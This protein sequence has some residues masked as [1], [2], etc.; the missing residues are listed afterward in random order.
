MHY[1]ILMRERGGQVRGRCRDAPYHA[2]EVGKWTGEGS[3]RIHTMQMREG[4][5]QVREV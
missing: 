4:G 5:G 2:H 3:V 1:T